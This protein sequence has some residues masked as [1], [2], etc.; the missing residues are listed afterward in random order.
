MLT[1]LLTEPF[2]AE[3]GCIKSI[4]SERVAEWTDGTTFVIVTAHGPLKLI[5]IRFVSAQINH[6]A[7]TQVVMDDVQNQIIA[8]ASIARDGVHVQGWIELG[9]LQ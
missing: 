8:K 5:A 6:A 4:G 1:R 9:Q 7:R 3:P 2:V